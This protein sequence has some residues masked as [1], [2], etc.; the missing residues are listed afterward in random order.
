MLSQTQI[1]VF[2]SKAIDFLTQ[3]KFELNEQGQ[4]E[5]E[6]TTHQVGPAIKSFTQ[7][8]LI[9]QLIVR[10]DGHLPARPLIKYGMTF[11][12]DA[13]VTLHT[14]RLLAVEVKIIREIDPS[15]SLSKAIGQ[16][17]MYR[18][19]GFECAIGLIFDLRKSRHS[20]LSNS[21]QSLERDPRTKFVLFN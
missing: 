16:T 17:Q 3:Q 12:P 2:F 21:L 10:Y 11:L 18:A 19:L 14:Q 13:Q 6:L 8:L 4:Q 20:S 9:N 1:E 15:G 7:N 5:R